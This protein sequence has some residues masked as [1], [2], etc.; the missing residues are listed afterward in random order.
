MMQNECERYLVHEVYVV[1]TVISC[2]SRCYGARSHCD[3]LFESVLRCSFTLWFPV[4]VG[5]TVLV[6]TV[7]SC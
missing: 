6:H 7:V 4:R 2:L 1:H 5:V 3:F